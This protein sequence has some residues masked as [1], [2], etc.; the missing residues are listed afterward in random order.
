MT[1]INKAITRGVTVKDLFVMS[2]NCFT[3]F[4][5]EFESMK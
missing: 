2:N 4:R 5:Y 1:V 3:T